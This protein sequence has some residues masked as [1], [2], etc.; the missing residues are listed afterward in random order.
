MTNHFR[1]YNVIY[2]VYDRKNE[3]HWPMIFVLTIIGNVNNIVR[4]KMI[5]HYLLLVTHYSEYKNSFYRLYVYHRRAWCYIIKSCTVILLQ[6]W[7]LFA[8][9]RILCIFQHLA[10]LNGFFKLFTCFSVFFPA[11][12]FKPHTI[13]PIDLIVRSLLESVCT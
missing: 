10:A 8:L 1:S 13:L 11:K 7:E 5:G 3:N 6:H 2:I 9:F 4:T 12:N